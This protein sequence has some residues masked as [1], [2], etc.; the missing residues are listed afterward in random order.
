M[1]IELSRDTDAEELAQFARG[2]GLSVS[3]NGTIVNFEDENGKIAAA[4]ATWLAESRAPLVP[5][6]LADG[7]LAL[8]PP[9]A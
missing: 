6:R 8:R 7:A 2:I 9:G 1:H 3:C 4:V 5:T